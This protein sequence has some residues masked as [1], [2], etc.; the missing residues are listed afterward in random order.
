MVIE[1]EAELIIGETE[2]KFLDWL[3]P[4]H[5]EDDQQS[6]Q[7]LRAID[8]GKWILKHETYKIWITKPGSLVWVNGESKLSAF[9]VALT[10]I[11]GTGKTFLTLLPF[12]CR[13]KV[14]QQSSTISPGRY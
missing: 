9:K 13:L 4:F 3:C 1:L 5:P 6:I 10:I 14:V 2:S 8:T 12:L 7:E 11:V